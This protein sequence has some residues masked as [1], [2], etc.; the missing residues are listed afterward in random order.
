MGSGGSIMKL[1]LAIM[2]AG[3]VVGLGMGMF[4]SGE[5]ATTKPALDPTN[6]ETAVFAGGCFWCTE[7]DFEKLDGVVDAVSGYTGGAEPDP[8]YEAVSSHRT[9][10]LEAVMV[11][12]D[13]RIVPYGDLVE[14]FWRHIDPTDAGGQF[15][16][17]G[18][19][20]RSAIFVRTDEERKTAERSREA[21]AKSGVFA[22][23]IATDIRPLGRFYRAE[24]YHQDFYKK[25]P[26]R[27]RSYRSGSGRESFAKKHWEGIPMKQK[28][29][30]KYT[31]PSDT[32]LRAKLTATQYRVAR[33]EGTEPPFENEYWDNKKEGIYVDIVSGEPLFSSKDKFNSG[34]GWPSFTRPLVP[35]NV[36]LHVDRSLFMTRTEVRSKHGDSH[37][38]HVFED[39]PAPTGLRYCIN[40]ASLRFIPTSDLEREGYAEF[41]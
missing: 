18:N 7:A 19:Q 13:P 37:L 2:A 39:G 4:G 1:G 9:S 5:A 14:Y 25:S 12:Y 16:D 20:Y 40:S 28:S 15:V 32:E 27:Y 36:A 23:P 3:S 41:K 26:L 35:E 31:V 38:G 6:L 10:H 29:A 30:G 11:Y 22:D 17:K 8:T 21:L 33:E 34:T 24:E